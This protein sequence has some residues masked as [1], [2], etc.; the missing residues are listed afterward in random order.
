[1]LYKEVKEILRRKNIPSVQEWDQAIQAYLAQEKE[2]K[3]SVEK[4]V[5]FT[6][7]HNS[8]HVHVEKGICMQCDKPQFQGGLCLF[9]FQMKYSENRNRERD[10]K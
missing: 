4:E 3:K 10:S 9:H 2:W 7:R 1:M 8:V 5:F 6:Q